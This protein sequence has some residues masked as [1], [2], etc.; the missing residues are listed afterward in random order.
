MMDIQCR[1]GNFRATLTAFPKNTPGRLVCYCNDCQAYL[2]HLGRTD[3]LD[4][5]GGTEVIPVYP[6]EMMIASGLEHLKCTRLTA[7]GTFRFS[8][9]CCNSPV[10]NTAAGMPW[11]GAFKCLYTHSSDQDIDRI[12]GPV[13]SRIMG[14]FAKGTPPAGTARKMNLQSAITVL[15][16]M[17]KGKMLG[18]SMPSPFFK[19]DG[20]T[21]VVLPEIVSEN[22]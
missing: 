2:Q 8:T 10:A 9:T 22:K 21:P 7:R 3:L 18:K 11:I 19:A 14:K 20:V 4:E 5:N 12:L 17:L 13:R 1:C 6:S 16:F 15:P